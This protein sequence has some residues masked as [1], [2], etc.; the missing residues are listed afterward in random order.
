[1]GEACPWGHALDPIRGGAWNQPSK[2]ANVY[3]RSRV[4][5]E[6]DVADRRAARV[7]HFESGALAGCEHG[8][9]LDMFDD[10]TLR[11]PVRAGIERHWDAH[12]Q[13]SARKA[14]LSG[15]EQPRHHRLHVREGH[16]EA[17]RALFFPAQAAL[18]RAMFD[19]DGVGHRA[20]RACKDVVPHRVIEKLGAVRELTSERVRHL[21]AARKARAGHVGTAGTPDVLA[22]RGARGRH[23]AVAPA[24]VHVLAAVE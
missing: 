24:V 22:R 9:K 18:D 2:D 1:M 11:W 3:I 17:E 19:R 15:A 8:L 6:R 13:P 20:P 16:I 5:K 14:R 12:R 7:F 4:V 21:V 10:E 23:D